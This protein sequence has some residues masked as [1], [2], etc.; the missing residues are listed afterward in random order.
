MP[1]P[2]TKKNTASRL[3]A[4]SDSIQDNEGA[5]VGINVRPLLFVEH[6]FYHF[7]L[8]PK[9]QALCG[10]RVVGGREGVDVLDDQIEGNQRAD[11]A[12]QRPEKLP[13]Q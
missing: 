3:Q 6:S 5:D 1:V 4:V 12:Q 10:L 2:A 7:H 11:S 9:W 13:Q 8:V